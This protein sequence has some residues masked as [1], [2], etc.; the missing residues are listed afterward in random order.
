MKYLLLMPLFFSCQ[1][2][3]LT[4]TLTYFQGNKS[5][6]VTCDSAFKINS[7]SAV[8]YSKDKADTVVADEF[9]FIEND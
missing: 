8:Y 3:K 6:S 4:Y 7:K 2:N 5:T 1:H 9:I